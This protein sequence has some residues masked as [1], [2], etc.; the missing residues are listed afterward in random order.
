MDI[1]GF[2]SNWIVRNVLLAIA[3]VAGF[4][5]LSSVFL[6]L[7]TQHGREITVPDFTN[8]TYD[9][10]R[11]AASSAGVRILVTDS[12]YVKR[13]KPGAVYLQTPKSGERVKRGR[14]IRL[15]TNTTVPKE[16]VMP[17]L[18]GYSMRQAK[19]ELIRSG[20][21]LGRLIYVRDIATNNVL[22]QQRGGV[23]IKA[24]TRLASGT[25]INLVVGLSPND[26]MT[27]SPKLVGKQYL[28][29]VDL[30]QESSL[31]V[32]KLHFDETV[33][34]YADSVSAVVYQQRPA[35]SQKV[36]MGSEMTFS[37]TT[38]LSKLEPQASGRK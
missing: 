35:G 28:H 17:A 14:R 23:D 7:I 11:K 19:A 22:R 21:V 16:V 31:N 15:T 5:L 34:T 37:L 6:S 13:L 12:V 18:V 25:T 32:G 20:L 26:N 8:M 1:K 38:D 4:V 33:K 36:R 9:E 27:Y 2:F 30:T 29:A 3:F 24:G 10:A